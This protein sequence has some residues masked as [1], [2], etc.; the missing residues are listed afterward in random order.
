MCFKVDPATSDV[1]N[2]LLLMSSDTG[3][4]YVM[5]QQDGGSLFNKAM[6]LADRIAGVEELPF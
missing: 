2:V 3:V 5:R 6:Y 4:W 1:L